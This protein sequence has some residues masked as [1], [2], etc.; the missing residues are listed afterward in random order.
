MDNRDYPWI[1]KIL[2]YNMIRPEVQVLGVAHDR[3]HTLGQPWAT[4]TNREAVTP[5]V[6]SDR[7]DAFDVLPCL[8]LAAFRPAYIGEGRPTR[9]VGISGYP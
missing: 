1:R 7:G 2:V 9:L 5:V 3:I 4:D 8:S 6:R